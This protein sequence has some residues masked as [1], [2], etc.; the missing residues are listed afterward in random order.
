MRIWHREGFTSPITIGHRR[1][2]GAVCVSHCGE[3]GL[4]NGGSLCIVRG[5]L[6]RD[7]WF[8]K[9]HPSPAARFG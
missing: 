6:E 2:G 7:L 1:G 4:S 3:W 5:F 9:G 8:V